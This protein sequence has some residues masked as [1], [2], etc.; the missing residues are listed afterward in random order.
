MCTVEIVKNTILP[1]ELECEVQR[2]I[3]WKYSIKVK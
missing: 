2:C 3:K 1:S